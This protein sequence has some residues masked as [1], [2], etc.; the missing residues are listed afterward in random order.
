[1]AGIKRST[2]ML[3]DITQTDYNHSDT[4][5]NAYRTHTGN[6][7]TLN[8]DALMVHR[9]YPLFVIADGM[10]GHSAGDRA[11]QYIVKQMSALKFSQS[12]LPSR[13][14]EIEQTI[15]AIN[16]VINSSQWVDDPSAI[17]GSTMVA[18]Y[19]EDNICTC[20]WIGDSRLYIYR[21]QRLYQ[22]TRDH[23]MVQDMVDRGLLRQEEAALHPNHNVLTRAV[24][25]E[26]R[27]KIDI[28]QFEIKSGDKLLLCSDGLYNELTNQNIIDCLNREHTEN[29]AEDLLQGVL[30]RNAADNVSLIVINKH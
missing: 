28:N 12:D 5:E 18:A 19:I 7:R 20:F 11:S 3:E 30:S 2:N 10:G 25:V 24:G 23:S 27:I 22:I 21:D 8:E 17:V 16:S 4:L 1:M 15:R 6:V 14:T 13:I 29:I 9:E 26:A